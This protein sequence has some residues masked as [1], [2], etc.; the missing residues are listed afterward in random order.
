MTVIDYATTGPADVVVEGRG[1][2]QTTPVKGGRYYEDTAPTCPLAEATEQHFDS[3]THT[4]RTCFPTDFTGPTKWNVARAAVGQQIEWRSLPDADAT[5][6]LVDQAD[7]TLNAAADRGSAIHR[8]IEARILGKP[9]DHEDM[10]RNGATE[11]L[12]SIEAFLLDTKPTP[13]LVETVAFGRATGTACT[14]DYLG[15]LADIGDNLALDWKSRTKNH[16]RRPKEAAQL[17]GIIDMARD[18]YYMDERGHRR[19]AVVDG[20]GIVTFAPDGTWAFHPVDPD[21]ATASWRAALA[22][23]EYT[24]VSNTYGKA[25]KGAPLDVAAV[26]KARFAAIERDTPEWSALAKAWTQHRLPAMSDDLTIDDWPTV[27]ALLT[28]AEP[29]PQGNAAPITYATAPETADVGQRLRALPSDLRD[30]VLRAA[31]GLRDLGSPV[32]SE[33]EL[34][35]WERLVTPAESAAA[36]RQVEVDIIIG[37]LAPDG[38]A[39]DAVMDHFPDVVA[40]W[41]DADV[42]RL[43]ELVDAYLAGDL[44]LRGDT[45]IV[46]PRVVESL[47]KLDTRMKAAEVAKTIGR[48]VP[49][50]FDE[51]MADVVLYAATRAA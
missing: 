20:A 10:A 7:V 49:K 25:R 2:R 28:R 12:A 23:R 29:F 11:Y 4:L 31:G 22:L 15:G 44:I 8:A 39:R 21:V 48:P 27:D 17:G 35:D 9:I 26:V 43:A 19:Q 34:E 45:L 6:W 36:G 1:W 32:L 46:S 50:K 40:Q 41:T 14:L 3:L 18:G 5:R 38:P 51:A 30:Q 33:D 42:T 16:D 13:T 47:P 37:Q 24:L